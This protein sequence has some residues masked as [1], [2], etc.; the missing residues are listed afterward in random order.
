MAPGCACPPSAAPRFPHLLEE[1][2]TFPPPACHEV[3]CR[4]ELPGEK[5]PSIF[6][7]PDSPVSPPEKFD[8]FHSFGRSPYSENLD[9]SHHR[10]EDD[11]P[12][13][14]DAI[15]SSFADPR[16]MARLVS[17]EVEYKFVPAGSSVFLQFPFLKHM[18]SRKPP[19]IRIPI[20]P[21]H[22]VFSCDSMRK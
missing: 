12:Q 5:R 14:S 19:V 15:A 17:A 21:P 13:I 2:R 4:R 18:T 11:T 7:K 6:R 10:I 16:S 20:F 3:F 9:V 8:P 22:G 1:A